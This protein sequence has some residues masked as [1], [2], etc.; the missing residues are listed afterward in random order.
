MYPVQ[1]KKVNPAM[2]GNAAANLACIKR[3]EAVAK[4]NLSN[5]DGDD[6]LSYSGDIAAEFNA[7]TGAGDVFVDFDGNN[8]FLDEEGRRHERIITITIE[9]ANAT[10][11]VIRILG[12][13]LSNERDLGFGFFP[14]VRGQLL[15]DGNNFAVSNNPITLTTKPNKWEYFRAFI[16]NNPS[17]C[18]GFKVTSTDANQIEQTILI[19]RESPFKNLQDRTIY[20]ANYQNE[21]T[22]RDKQVTVP[23]HIQFDDQ[24][25][26]ETTIV[27]NST[28]TIT[29]YFGAVLNLGKTLIK[30]SAIA[31]AMTEKR[32]ALGILDKKSEYLSDPRAMLGHG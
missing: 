7:Y 10:D 16:K 13:L 32:L 1:V 23:E 5:F 18:L 12:G 9:N 26:I 2:V 3:L 28:M 17:R 19:K 31:G 11:E 4:K 15:A 27:A 8:S 21:H 20:L 6:L 14:M 29:F 30:K 24:Q 22:F 25:F